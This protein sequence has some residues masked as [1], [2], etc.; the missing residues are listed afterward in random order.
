VGGGDHGLVALAKHDVAAATRAMPK[1]RAKFFTKGARPFGGMQCSPAEDS[2]A[3]NQQIGLVIMIKP[4]A[5]IVARGAQ[6]KVRRK[7]MVSAA[8]SLHREGSLR[9]AHRGIERLE[10]I[11]KERIER[12]IEARCAK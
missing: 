9:G 8:A 3:R 11:L 2:P 1:M 4:C 10:H 5:Q 7:L 6:A 12:K